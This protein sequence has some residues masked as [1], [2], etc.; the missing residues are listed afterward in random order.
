M[1]KIKQAIE[2]GRQREEYLCCFAWLKQTDA[3]F[4]GGDEKKS[5]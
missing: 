1:K 5:M 3:E 2:G 4:T